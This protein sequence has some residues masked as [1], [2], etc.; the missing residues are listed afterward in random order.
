MKKLLFFF[1]LLAQALTA[2]GQISTQSNRIN[3]KWKLYESTKFSIRH[4]SNWELNL[5]RKMGETFIL[6]SPIETSQDKFRENVNLFE[7]NLLSS[8]FSLDQYAQ[9]SLIQIKNFITNFIL[10]ENKRMKRGPTEYHQLVYKGDQ[11]ILKLIFTQNIW[12]KG[13]KAHIL[14]FTSEQSKYSKYKELGESTLNT[15]SLK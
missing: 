10:I 1:L 6:Y 14:T 13:N 12:I 5:D 9:S 3:L 7:E 15:F 11:G 2:Y 8:N 4:P